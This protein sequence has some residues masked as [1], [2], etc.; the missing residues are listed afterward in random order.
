[1]GTANQWTASVADTHDVLVI[2]AGAAGLTAAGGC[3]MFGLK[4]ALIER[5]AMGGDCLNTGCVPSKALLAAAARAQEVR[6][7]GRFGI[8]AGEPRIDFAGV[9]AHVHGVIA[10]IAPKDGRERFEAMGVEV[11]AGEARFT[12]DRAL[13][14]NG[15]RLAAPRVVIAT[16]SRP[17]IPDVLAGLP[18][19]TNETIFELEALPARLAII[20]GGPVGVEMAQAF[21]RLGSAVDLVTSGRLLARDDE[22]AVRVVREQLQ[23]EGIVIHEHTEL[24]RAEQV[25]QDV[26]LHLHGGATLA[27]TH[28]LA[29]AGR[30]VDLGALNLAAVGLEAG[31]DGIAVDA[32]RRTPA[33]GVYAIGDCRKGPRFTHA[34]GRDGAAVVLAIALGW[35]SKVNGDTLPAVTY[36]DPELAQLGPTEA[37]A[38]SR[39]GK[40]EVAVEPFANDDRAVAEG[41]TEGFI[42]TVHAGR[43]L[44]GVTIVGRSAGDLLLPWGLVMAGKASLFALAQ[45]VVAYPTRSERSKE[46]AFRRY[47]PLIFG[48][49]AK[50]WARRLASRRRRR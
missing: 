2:G 41:S 9:R 11:I 26:V 50:A 28:V 15:R 5:G 32:N 16:G 22:D 39:L 34:S 25:G 1:M 3:A 6:T 17:V 37:A 18:V 33:K 19:L 21:R 31:K 12:G 35:S 48:K 47:E 45:T 38:R 4:V 7:A 10:A 44:V 13:E 14:V 40:V 30:H 49:A 27:A 36:T 43:K 46:V 20:G 8:L 24:E 42:K 29:A 23:R